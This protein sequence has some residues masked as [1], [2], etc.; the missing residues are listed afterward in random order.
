M[1]RDSKCISCGKCALVCGQGAIAVNPGLSR[2]ID[3]DRC[4][5][6][7]NFVKA[8]TN[9]A[10]TVIGK[11]VTV[12]EVISEAERDRI[13]YKNSGGG[14]T[15]SGGE[16]LFQPDFSLKL[17]QAV[18]EKGL[19][20]AVETSGFAQPDTLS[21]ILPYTDLLLFDIKQ[22]DDAKHKQYTGVG[23][24]LILS[25]LRMAAGKVRT[26]IRI[27]LIAGFNDSPAE[28]R[29]I[30]RMARE[31]GVEKVSLLPYHEGGVSKHAQVGKANGPFPGK[32]PADIHIA[33]LVKL[34]RETGVKATV[35]S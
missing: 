21:A 18:K 4:D 33:D 22:L 20:T 31:L 30:S 5:Q 15:L 13:F 25:N 32:S 28:I 27:P 24:G 1:S 3:W 8:C 10:L 14:V 35:G 23:N 34:A 6:C 17:L 29:D 19:H 16:P 9:E 2:S 7:F 11:H 26:W 12:E